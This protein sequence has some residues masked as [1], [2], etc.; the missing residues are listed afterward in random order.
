MSYTNKLIGSNNKIIGLEWRMMIQGLNLHK[1]TMG[2]LDKFK[3][4]LQIN[5]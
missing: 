1:K 2:V 5:M 3:E 4:I